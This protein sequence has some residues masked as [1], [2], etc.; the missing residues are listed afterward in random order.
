MN[1]SNQS[2]D[3]RV[4]I[5]AAINELM[6]ET[7]ELTDSI[8]DINDRLTNLA[9]STEEILAETDVVMDISVSVKARLDELNRR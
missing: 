7:E 9:A 2:D 1:L 6:K 8:N 5:V 4:E 3:N